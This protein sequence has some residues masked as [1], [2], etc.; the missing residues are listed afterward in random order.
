MKRII[1]DTDPGVDDALAI[2]M[3]LNHPETEVLGFVSVAGNVPS[4]R[5][6]KNIIRILDAYGA[7]KDLYDRV[8][9]GSP[10]PLVRRLVTAEWV[11]G[12]DGLGDAGLP[13]ASREPKKRALKFLLDLL[14][15][16]STGE[17]SLLCIGPLTN[18]ALLASI[19]PDLTSRIGEV[20]IMGGWFAQ[21]DFSSGN[22]T[23]VAEFNVYND[24]E[25]ASIVFEA[26]GEKVKAVGLDVTT[27][28][29]VMLTWE[30]WQTL[31]N[32]SGS[33]RLAAKLIERM[34]R[35]F[36]GG[37]AP[38]DPLAFTALVKPDLFEFRKYP[39]EV[40]LGE[41]ATRGQVIV[42]KRKWLEAS[43]SDSEAYPYI[44]SPRIWVASR[45][46]AVE[47]KEY[48]IRYLTV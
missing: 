26:F 19:A 5:G 43:S 28:P 21:T 47:A 41:G 3:S 32:S 24:P 9:E 12:S 40:S 25:A 2:L 16:A 10:K 20:V 39:V 48:I 6:A 29:D 37:M 33:G 11:H 44:R 31:G 27:H 42:D 7:D 30:D 45:I 36:H 17:V 14:E 15:S 46:K 23:P 4:N 8:Y 1:I 34:L 38:H 13:E 18:I 35:L 22:A